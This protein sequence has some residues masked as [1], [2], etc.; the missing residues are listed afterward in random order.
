MEV[1][2]SS[3]R[4]RARRRL[5]AS[6][7]VALAIALLAAGFAVFVQPFSSMGAE[8]DGVLLPEGAV[9]VWEDRSGDAWCLFGDCPHLRRIAAIPNGPAEGCAAI[10]GTLAVTA[11]DGLTITS[12]EEHCGWSY[13]IGRTLVY[14]SVRNPRDT[15]PDGDRIDVPHGA[16]VVLSGQR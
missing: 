12:A 2:A 9:V 3:R 13:R 5:L 16:T 15:D 4:R 11:P 8:L 7:F 1:G 6:G 14:V 10:A